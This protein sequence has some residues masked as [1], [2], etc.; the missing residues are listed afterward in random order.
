MIIFHIN[1][2]GYDSNTAFQNILN[3]TVQSFQDFR[4]IQR[5]LPLFP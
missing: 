5:I 4:R 2:H 1:F 3:V